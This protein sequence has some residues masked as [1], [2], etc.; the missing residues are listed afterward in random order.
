MTEGEVR[1]L[2]DDIKA[3]QRRPVERVLDVAVRL[4][5]PTVFGL[6]AWLWTLE[7]QAHRHDVR[8]SRIEESRFTNN[9]GASLLQSIRDELRT[10]YPPK[11]L[12]DAIVRMESAAQVTEARFVEVT[13]RLIRLEEQIRQLKE[14]KND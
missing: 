5:I 7:E 14:S 12:T 9:D 4:L 8:L 10:N 1:Q 13:E 11:W 2:R 3:L 6:V